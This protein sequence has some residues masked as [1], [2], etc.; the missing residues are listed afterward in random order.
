[1]T[2]FP[3]HGLAFQ[4]STEQ[5]PLTETIVVRIG[6]PITEIDGDV[7]KDDANFPHA[8]LCKHEGCTRRAG[9]PNFH[10]GIPFW[11]R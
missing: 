5:P 4:R 10:F 7:T 11:A 2:S 1:M 8:C 3:S 9:C 6:F